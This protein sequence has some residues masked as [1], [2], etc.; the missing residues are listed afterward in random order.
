MKSD[1]KNKV[2]QTIR[3]YMFENQYPPTVREIMDDVGI[4][5]TSTVQ[6]YIER[7]EEDGKIMCYGSPRT[8]CLPGVRYI[9]LD[10]IV[11]GLQDEKKTIDK[12][13]IDYR[14]GFMAA[15]GVIE[16]IIE[17]DRDGKH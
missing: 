14:K 3:Q 15:I 6:Y 10:D 12:K 1:N 11:E 8:I 13:T 16:K 4:K 7:L 5:S 9:D 2:Y 17:G